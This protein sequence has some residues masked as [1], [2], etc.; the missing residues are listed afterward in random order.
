M[1]GGDLV[2]FRGRREETGVISRVRKIRK[3]QREVERSNSQFSERGFFEPP[4]GSVI[5][6]DLR[7]YDGGNDLA[8]QLYSYAALRANNGRWYTT[9]A[10]CPP[11]GWDWRALCRWVDNEGELQSTPLAWNGRR[12]AI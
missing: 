4:I 6:F 3:P 8:G 9:G 2:P 1:A 7:F 12:N 11:Q 10:S 5:R